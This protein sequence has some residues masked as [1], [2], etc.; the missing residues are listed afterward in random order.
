MST[1]RK[2]KNENV[3]S[4]QNEEEEI[5]TTSASLDSVSLIQVVQDD[6]DGKFRPVIGGY[7]LN[8]SIQELLLNLKQPESILLN[9]TIIYHKLHAK[10]AL[11]KKFLYN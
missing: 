11:Y 2:S 6:S 8:E 4:E 7:F 9:F 1:K 5:G 10:F 3:E